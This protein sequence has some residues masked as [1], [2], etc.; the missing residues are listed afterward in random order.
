ML[1]S[2]PSRIGPIFTAIPRQ[3]GLDSRR[4]K[5]IIC[6]TTSLKTPADFPGLRGC[7]DAATRPN[8]TSDDDLWLGRA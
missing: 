6:L 7:P 2:P 8:L 1:K 3:A 4:M 5:S